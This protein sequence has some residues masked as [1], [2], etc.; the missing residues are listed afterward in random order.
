MIFKLI[1]GLKEDKNTPRL[2]EQ[3][4]ITCLFSCKEQ[5]VKINMWKC[6]MY[7]KQRNGMLT[8]LLV[9]VHMFYVRRA[10]AF[11]SSGSQRRKNK[12]LCSLSSPWYTDLPIAWVSPTHWSYRWWCFIMIKNC[13]LPFASFPH[14][15]TNCV[16][17]SK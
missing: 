15:H 11:R 4:E 16:L 2:Y 8:F 1:L 10:D 7:I 3:W 14:I 5:H 12:N 17:P 13:F 9:V 6:V